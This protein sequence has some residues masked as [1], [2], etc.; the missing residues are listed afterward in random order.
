[1]CS[2]A[3][4]ICSQGRHSWELSLVVVRCFE[5]LFAQTFQT[6]PSSRRSKRATTP[7]YSP[8]LAVVSAVLLAGGRRWAVR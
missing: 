5:A 6:W 4:Q 1:M 7:I 2:G 3:S 8:F